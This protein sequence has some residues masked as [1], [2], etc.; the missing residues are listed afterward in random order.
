MKISFKKFIPG[1]AWFFVVLFLIC[2]PG[3]AIPKIG[4]LEGINF[5]KLVHMG[6]FALLAALFCWPVY[7]SSLSKKK[8]IKYFIKIAIATSVWGLATELIQKYFIVGRDYE[9]LDWAA[10]SLGALIAFW[11]CSKK[12]SNDEQRYKGTSESR[13]DRDK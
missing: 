7:N 13:I 5:D 8:R 4:W 10:D 11:F 6:I 9:L 3:K 2:L 12:F 1:I